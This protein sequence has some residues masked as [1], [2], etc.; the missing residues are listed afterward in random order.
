MIA[1][2]VLKRG[3]RGQLLE[4]RLHRYAYEI[5]ILC[6]DHKELAHGIF[7]TNVLDA[8]LTRSSVKLKTRH[9]DRRQPKTDQLLSTVVCTAV[10]FMPIELAPRNLS[11][12]LTL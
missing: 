12:V 6:S 2:V 8:D 7:Q 1:I 4:R 9:P 3:F 10:D 11:F 5:K